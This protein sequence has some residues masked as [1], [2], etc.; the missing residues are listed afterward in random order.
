MRKVLAL[1]ESTGS[2]NMQTDE[3]CSY[4]R[5]LG[6][7]RSDYERMDVAQSKPVAKLAVPMA[8]VSWADARTTAEKLQDIS[9]LALAL[10]M[11]RRGYEV[12]SN[13]LSGRYASGKKPHR[14]KSKSK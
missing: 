6:V 2:S 7:V 14:R 13:I 9:D 8:E 5:M 11:R 12:A 4:H 3:P 1:D 10:E